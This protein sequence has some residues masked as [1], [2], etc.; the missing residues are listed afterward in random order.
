MVQKQYPNVTTFSKTIRESLSAHYN[1]LTAVL[2]KDD[3]IYTSQANE[4]NNIIDS[5]GGDAFK[6]G[7]IYGL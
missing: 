5:I 6:G 7:L 2:F 3:T 1:M 4:M